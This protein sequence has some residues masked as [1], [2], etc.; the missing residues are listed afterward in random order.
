[1]NDELI[2]DISRRMKDG[3]LS[4]DIKKYLCERKTKDELDIC[5]NCNGHNLLVCEHYSNKIINPIIKKY[6]K[7]N[8]K[9]D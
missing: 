6:K 5:K 7:E 9:K 8:Y 2:N 3:R 4:T 1:M